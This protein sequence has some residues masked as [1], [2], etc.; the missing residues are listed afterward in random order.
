MTQS[1][2]VPSQAA[3][4]E[5]GLGQGR[6]GGRCAGGEPG[7]RPQNQPSPWKGREGALLFKSG[8]PVPGGSQLGGSKWSEV[9]RG[10]PLGL[11][12]ASSCL[13][14]LS[15][16][17]VGPCGRGTLE[18]A[19]RRC[20]DSKVQEAEGLCDLKPRQQRRQTGATTV[21]PFASSRCF[22]GEGVG[23]DG[24]PM[25]IRLNLVRRKNVEVFFRVTG[26]PTGLCF[27]HVLTTLE[28]VGR[29]MDN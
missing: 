25:G 22:L 20:L 29:V 19:A 4:C 2:S 12:V 11:H 10:R 7:P 21:R 27:M 18:G 14:G 6:R 16:E 5:G 15:Q 28:S 8:K 1:H 9:G 24:I 17:Q 23:K 13:P 26:G 3:R